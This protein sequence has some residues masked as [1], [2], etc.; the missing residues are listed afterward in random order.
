MKTR[1]LGNFTLFLFISLLAACGG[2]GGG[3]ADSAGSVG[4]GGTDGE[5]TEILGAGCTSPQLPKGR[6]S[7]SVYSIGVTLDSS[8]DVFVGGRFV[9]YIEGRFTSGIARLN[10]DSSF[11]TGFV[12]G[13]GFNHSHSVLTV[14]PAND[15]SGDVYVGGSFTSYNGSAIGRIAR[16]NLDGSLDTDFD[17]GIGLDDVVSIIVSSNDG[18]GDVYVGGP[19]TSYNGTAVGSGLIRLNDDGSLD[20]GFN[21]DSGWGEF[22]IAP[23]IDGSGDVYVA[24]STGPGIARLNN[25][26]SI[27]AGFDTGLTGFNDRVNVIA[28]ATDGSGDVYVGGNFSDYNGVETTGIVRLNSDGSLDMGFVAGP[29]FEGSIHLITLAIDGS[30]DIYADTKTAGSIRRLNNDGSID[31]GFA[32]GSG[33]SSPVFFSSVTSIALATDGSGDVYIGIGRFLLALMYNGVFVDNLVR[34]TQ[35][36]V[37]VSG[38][39]VF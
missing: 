11:D 23:A 8:D 17:T 30:G 24:R 27:D 37:L 18:S 1:L 35:G 16:L 28:V 33:F 36:G 7:P 22:A 25:D 13:S 20:S 32:T 2:G 38:A 15:G 39:L 12:T 31:D 26:G 29:Q 5:C 21:T 14:A 19:F 6:F 34:L 3:S 9:N 10:N 4:S